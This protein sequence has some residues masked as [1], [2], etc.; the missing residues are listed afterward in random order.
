MEPAVLANIFL[1]LGALGLNI[2]I[3]GSD[4]SADDPEPNQDPLYNAQNYANAQDGTEGNDT[5]SADADNQAWFLHGGD[6]DLTASSANDYANLGDGDDHAVMGAGNDIGLGGAGNDSLAGGVGADSLFGGA[7]NDQMQGN[8]GDDGLAGGDGNDEVWGGLGGDILNG[9]AG[10]DTLSGFVTGAAG[11]GGMTG[12]EGSDQLVGGDGNDLLVLGHGDIAQ[13]GSGNDTFDLDTRWNDGSAIAHI[14]DYNATQDALRI[15]YTPHYSTDSSAEVP[16]VMTLTQTPDGSTEI[17]MDGAIVAQLDG[18]NDFS[19]NDIVL[20]PDAATDTQFVMGNYTDDVQGSDGIDSLSGGSDPTAWHLQGGADHLTGSTG[21]DYAD[22]GAGQDQAT[23]G[24]GNDSVL[25]QGGD[26]SID[27]GLGADTLRGGDG[28]D[29]LHGGDGADRM[30]G[31]LGNDLLAGGAGADSLLGGGGDDTLSGYS[32]THSSEASLTAIDGADTLSGGDGN[33]TLIIG[34]GDTATGGAGADRFEIE[35]QWADG[36]A[37]ATITDYTFQT[38]QLELHYTPHFDANNVEIPPVVTVAQAAGVTAISLDG[39]VVANVI[40][41]RA[42][43]LGEVIL[44]R[45]G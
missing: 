31:D 7:G 36:T 8:L 21:A 40:A 19:L 44:V 20:V 4:D 38:D 1:F 26:D 12:A 23:M 28:L 45:E 30:A 15:T 9:G 17:R 10:D 37:A 3:G 11:A 5:V 41:T 34:H 35:N 32:D 29:T 13:G 18:V 22:L 43:G 16:P 39:V 42:V 25:G 2:G 27:G 24:G 6:D 14:V 33:D